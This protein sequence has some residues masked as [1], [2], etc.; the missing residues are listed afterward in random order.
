MLNSGCFEEQCNSKYFVLNQTIKVLNLS[1]LKEIS[2]KFF[3]F[4]VYFMQN[5]VSLSKFERS[6]V[7]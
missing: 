3:Y 6:S 5:N 4:S 1:S 7:A 2:I